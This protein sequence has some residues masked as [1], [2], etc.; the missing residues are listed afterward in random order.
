MI[1][2]ISCRCSFVWQEREIVQEHACARLVI[3]CTNTN[4]TELEY[5]FDKFKSMT[6]SGRVLDVWQVVGCVEL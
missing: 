5:F 6:V 4:E 1:G 2:F 3:R